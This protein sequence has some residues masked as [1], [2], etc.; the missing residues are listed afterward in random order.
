MGRVVRPKGC[1]VDRSFEDRKKP[2]QPVYWVRL[3]R[4]SCGRAKVLSARSLSR[5]A[6]RNGSPV[7]KKS[8]V[9]P[10]REARSPRSPVGSASKL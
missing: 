6:A 5:S 7:V 10:T 2:R 9:V 3:H 1:G 8:R 4:G